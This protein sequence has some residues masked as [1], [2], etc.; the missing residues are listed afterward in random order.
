MKLKTVQKS[1]SL[2][3]DTVGLIDAYARKNHMSFS[4]ALRC[5]VLAA[6]EE[7]LPMDVRKSAVSDNADLP[8]ALSEVVPFCGGTA[9]G[10]EHG[11]NVS[12]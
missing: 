10:V 1:V 11:E 8:E 9:G 2:D 12:I 6:F 7:L 3:K 5:L 4:C